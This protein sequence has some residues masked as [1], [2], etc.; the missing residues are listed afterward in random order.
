M[1]GVADERRGDDEV[2]KR[3]V[4]KE[5]RKER[6]KRGEEKKRAE[7]QKRRGIRARAT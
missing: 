7:K 4:V 2:G 3:K 1:E 6:D 5:R